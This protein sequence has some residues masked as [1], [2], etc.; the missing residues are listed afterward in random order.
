MKLIIGNK[1]Y[2]TWSLRP[3]IAMTV[4]G[5]PFEEQVVP[6]GSD[7]FKRVVPGQSG[8]G[9]VPL[10][11]DGDIRVWESLAI[12]EYLAEKFPDA[13]LWPRDTGARAY[14]RA[15]ANEMH[16]G[17]RAMRGD[18]PMN[19][20]RRV[21]KRP[22]LPAV[23]AD[24]RRIDAIWAECRKRYGA[25]GPFLFG[26]RFTNA[27]AMY[28]P[29]ASRFRT[30]AVDLSPE[31]AAYRDA[32]LALPAYK[33]WAAAGLAEPWLVEEDEVDWPAVHRA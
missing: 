17:F 23:E 2:S 7:D 4:A 1:N 11:I 30:Y 28:A 12:L 25:G 3:W 10:L 26:A 32:I 29:V 16:A 33:A 15:I 9:L 19:I 31:S 22:P 6:F 20:A 18:M 21:M 8:N 5:I 14:A 24:V 13:V 27:D